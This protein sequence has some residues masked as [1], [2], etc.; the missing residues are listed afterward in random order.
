MLATM[1][2]AASFPAAASKLSPRQHALMVNVFLS[3]VQDYLV[4]GPGYNYYRSLL[5]LSVRDIDLVQAYKVDAIAADTYYR[6]KVVIVAG[7]LLAIERQ[8]SN[9][10]VVAKLRGVQANLC[11]SQIELIHDPEKSSDA[12][13][14]VCAIHT[15]A[16]DGSV[17]LSDCAD[18][19]ATLDRIARDRADQVEANP[20]LDPNSKW[21]ALVKLLPAFLPAK[22]TCFGKMSATCIDDLRMAVA[23]WNVSV[24]SKDPAAQRAMSMFGQ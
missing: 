22:T 5:A 19:G 13:F 6:N 14:L 21:I 12:V 1:Q 2:P 11:G 15:V 7:R 10:C 18:P 23:N 20:T 24:S 17:W 8:P 3:E 9:S 4:G 16:K